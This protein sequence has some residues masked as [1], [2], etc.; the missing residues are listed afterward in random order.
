MGVK[1]CR[2]AQLDKETARQGSK[3]A[4]PGTCDGAQKL[5]F[6]INNISIKKNKNHI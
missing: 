6:R 4:E 1:F 5:G 2:P 3:Y